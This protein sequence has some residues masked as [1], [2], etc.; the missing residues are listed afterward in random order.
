MQDDIIWPAIVV[1]VV[2]AML[3]ALGIVLRDV[4]EHRSE[5][6]RQRYA[7][8]D[9]TQRVSFITD[10]WNAKQAIGVGSDELQS[11][12]ETVQAWL[13]EAISQVSESMH[14]TTRPEGQYSVMRRVLL[15][16]PFKRVSAQFLRVFYY[17]VVYLVVPFWMLGFLG[18]IPNFDDYT[19]DVWA[20][21]IFMFVFLAVL[22][23]GLRAWAVSIEERAARRPTSASARPP[24]APGPTSVPQSYPP[25]SYPQGSVPSS[26][27]GWYGPPGSP[28]HHGWQ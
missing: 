5:R 20:G 8:D 13:K 7:I 4:Y 6:G 14:P 2:T 28:A 9:A 22:A 18:D 24:E 23:L 12:Q 10:W 26:A 16:Y 11:A 19:A 21:I 17:V 27:M 3:G 25:Q 1:P 15:A